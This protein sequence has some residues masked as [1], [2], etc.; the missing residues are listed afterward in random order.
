MQGTLKTLFMKE[1]ML[2]EMFKITSVICNVNYCAMIATKVKT[3]TK[4]ILILLLNLH[5]AVAR[6]GTK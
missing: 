1:I 5:V 2:G 4:I 3:V 6:R